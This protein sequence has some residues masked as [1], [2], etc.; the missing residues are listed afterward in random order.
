M[1]LPIFETPANFAKRTD[2]P[3]QLIRSMVKQGQ[4]PHM[5]TGKC[6]V[7]IHVEASLEAIKQYSQ[8]SATEIAASMPVPIKIIKS[9]V[10]PATDRKYKGRPPD[11]VRLA[12]KKAK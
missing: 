5:K 7:R 6:H 2:L 4:L 10:K 1:S 8:Q 11:S 9:A 12:M 3:E